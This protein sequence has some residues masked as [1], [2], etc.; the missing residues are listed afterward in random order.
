MIASD[1][2]DLIIQ[3]KAPMKTFHRRQL[4]RPHAIS[5]KLHRQLTDCFSFPERVLFLDI[6]TTGLS[7]YYDEITIIGWS[8]GGCAKTLVKGRD[9]RPLYDDVARAKALVTFNGIRFDA[10]FIARDFPDIVLPETHVDLRYLCRRVDLKGG[11]KAIESTLGIN[12]RGDLTNMDGAE[13]VLLWHRYVRGDLDAL[14]KLIRY[15]RIDVA[16][17]GAIFDEVIVRICPQLDLFT[18]HVRFRD[19]SAPLGWHKLP[20]VFSPSRQL[21]ERRLG[22][23]DL[24]GASPFSQLRIVGIDLTSTLR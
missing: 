1:F 22:Y 21:T 10:R 13:A 12:F 20:R 19:W 23:S 4:P 11:Q 2:G 9:P 7:H 8:F 16:A 15:N 6:E 3:S 18:E 24:F 17:M 5:R 14:R